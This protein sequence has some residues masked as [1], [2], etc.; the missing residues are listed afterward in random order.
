MSRLLF[1]EFESGDTVALDS[2]KYA[3]MLTALLPPGKLW[4]MIGSTL[5]N[6]FEAC[7]VE[8]ARVEARVLNLFDEADPRTAV[9]LLPEYERDLDLSSDGTTD[10]RRAR[11]VARLVARQRFRPVDFQ[12]ALAQLLG[13]DPE[14]VVV[15][16]RTHADAVALGDAREIFR[17]FIY[18]DPALPGSYY[19]DSAQEVVDQI[20]PSHT[21]GYVI[22]SLDFLCDD[23]HS[24]CDRDLLGA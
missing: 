21:I 20:K 17:F 8:L 19:I 3:R 18:R 6:L 23:P 1:L 14:D 5:S 15:L 2:G 12:N 24:L 22:E 10:Q 7:A 16:E 4:R 9:E 11:I 13:Q